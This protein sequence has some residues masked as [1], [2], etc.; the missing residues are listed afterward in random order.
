MR[1]L[2]LILAMGITA[3]QTDETV[4][5]YGAADRTWVLTSLDG[6]AFA[7]RAHLSFP[8]QGSVVGKGPC[9]SFGA[10]QSAP[11]PWIDIKG[12]R[13]TRAACADLGLEQDFFDALQEMTLS[14]VAGDTLILSNDA[15][16]EMVF[17][18]APSDP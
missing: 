14:E 5:G 6:T 12:I 10:S 9:N 4:S 16:R 8:E 3:C 18:A 2:T 13:A 7:A 11:Y 17:T 15:G 1:F